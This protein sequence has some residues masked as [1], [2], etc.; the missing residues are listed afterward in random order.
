VGLEQIITLIHENFPTHCPMIPIFIYL[1]IYLK[2][3]KSPKTIMQ[4]EESHHE[5]KKKKRNTLF[6]VPFT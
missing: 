6:L 3:E 5:W 2:G 1:F 4:I